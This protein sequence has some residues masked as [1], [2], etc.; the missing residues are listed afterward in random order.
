MKKRICVL[1]VCINILTMFLGTN[2]YA[3]GVNLPDDTFGPGIKYLQLS[4]TDGPLSDSTGYLTGL[5]LNDKAGYVVSFFEEQEIVTVRREG[6]ILEDDDV[7]ATGDF[8]CIVNS[9]SLITDSISIVVKGD[10]TGDGKITASD[11]MYI[12]RGISDSFFLRGCYSKAADV[13]EDGFVKAG[14]YM[15]LKK[16][17]AG[18]I[19]L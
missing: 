4:S 17:I 14:D 18:K 7:V 12:K 10:T 5:K 15:R 2:V 13:N 16:M 11:Y 1:L 9:E 3:D 6:V 19:E 8:V